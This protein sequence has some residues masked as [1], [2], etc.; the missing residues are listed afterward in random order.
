MVHDLEHAYKFFNDV[1]LHR[2][3][4]SFFVAVKEVM[5]QGIL[6]EYRLDP[7]F[8]DKLNYLIS[9]MNT[10]VAHSV[11]FLRAILIDCLLHRENKSPAGILSKDAIWKID[12]IMKTLI[13]LLP[14]NLE[15]KQRGQ[16]FEFTS[17][18]HAG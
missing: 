14:L 16:S 12:T 9:D 15:S 3:Q 17:Q 8:S 11:Q 18:L 13:A 2:G 6:D 5:K 7:T 10:H 1:E 4:K